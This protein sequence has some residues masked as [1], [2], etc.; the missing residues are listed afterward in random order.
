ML[1]LSALIEG[2]SRRLDYQADVCLTKREQ[3][4]LKLICQGYSQQEIS[5][6]LQIAPA[7]FETYRKHLCQ[8]LGAHC[9]RDLPLAAYQANLLALL[10]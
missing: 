2:Q 7:T 5:S 3:E 10:E 8:K 4:V 1:E 9:E 6:A